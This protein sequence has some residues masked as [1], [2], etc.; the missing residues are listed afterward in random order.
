MM[1]R[2]LVKSGLPQVSKHHSLQP[3]YFNRGLVT[4]IQKRGVRMS[5]V[6]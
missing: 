6:S 1:L 5:I 4:A 2:Q 3:S